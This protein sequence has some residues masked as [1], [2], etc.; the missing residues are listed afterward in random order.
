MYAV[1]FY[2]DVAGLLHTAVAVLQ[3]LDAGNTN[4]GTPGT[5]VT[6]SSVGV[7]SP[8]SRT[9][10]HGCTYSC[11]PGVCCAGSGVWSCA[12]YGIPISHSRRAQP[13]HALVYVCS[14]TVGSGSM[15]KVIV[16]IYV[17]LSSTKPQALN[18]HML[19]GTCIQCS[20]SALTPRTA[21][22]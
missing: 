13:V 2:R 21:D 12:G 11:L 15:Q 6:R 10:T 19:P 7:Q 1:S 3:L 5:A 22:R 4:S 9:T 16:R 17:Q 8:A 20:S 18:I 14:S